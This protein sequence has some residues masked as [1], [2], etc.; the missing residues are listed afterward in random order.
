MPHTH[1]EKPAIL[2]LGAASPTGR[3]FAKGLRLS[4]K[5][6]SAE[7]IGADIFENYYTIGESLFDR[8]VR[9]PRFNEKNHKIILEGLISKYRIAACIVLA[10]L[11]VIELAD[12]I[13][14]A[15][16]FLPNSAF[17]TVA[18][19]KSQVFDVLGPHGLSPKYVNNLNKRTFMSQ[20][21]HAGIDFPV[22]LRAGSAGTTSGFGSFLANTSAEIQCWFGLTSHRDVQAVEYLPG[23]NWACLMTYNDGVM[24]AFAI[25]ERIS[26][27]MAR[28]AIS[29]VTGNISVGQIRW[30]RKVLEI[31]QSAIQALESLSGVPANGFLTVD[32]K[33]SINGKPLVTEIN[34]KPVA[35]VGSFCHPQYNLSAHC[36]D[37]TLGD[38]PK[39]SSLD[40]CIRT[41]LKCYSDEAYI[42][43]DVDGQAL[44]VN[45]I[46]LPVVGKEIPQPSSPDWHR[47]IASHYSLLER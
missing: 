41:Y 21:L 22:W 46:K 35:C 23:K 31:S 38:V 28:T 10:E 40:Q 17:S 5:Y 47:T 27:I 6:S 12:T 1:S 32:L 43:R 11:E 13:L 9:M 36:V 29:G 18:G 44:L 24:T 7:L 42:L 25:Y 4:R 2:I 14:S 15:P 33:E 39:E 20:L 30:N 45:N 8:L 34:L 3:S 16:T 26:Y 19:S 37:L